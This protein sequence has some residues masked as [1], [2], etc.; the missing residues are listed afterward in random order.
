MYID[1]GA[2]S[3]HSTRVVVEVEEG[4][5]SRRG[6]AGCA[7]EEMAATVKLNGGGPLCCSSGFRIVA[8]CDCRTVI[9]VD[10]G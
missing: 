5:S 1:R 6:G 4:I 3:K 7:Q 10:E 8:T 9:S 2:D